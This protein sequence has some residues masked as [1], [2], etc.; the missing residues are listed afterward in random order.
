MV[1]AWKHPIGIDA[2]KV[3]EHFEQLEQQHGRITTSLVLESARPEDSLLH[4]Y[5]EWNDGI[6][7]EKYRKNQANQIITCLVTVIE[8]TEK[9]EP[10]R[11][12]VS[13]IKDKKREFRTINTVLHN[14]EYME[15]LLRTAKRELLA[16]Q[17][18]YSVLSELADVFAVIDTLV[19]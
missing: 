19:E 16:F 10:V 11:A 14:E 9:P 13:I 1:Y 18:K 17:K 8:G 4:S 12:V 2:Q 5:F 3:G 7:A 15:Q 6:A